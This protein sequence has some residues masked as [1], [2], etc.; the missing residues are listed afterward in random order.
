MT[1]DAHHVDLALIING[2][3]H[4]LAVYGKTLVLRSIGVVPPLKRVI[5]M[6]GVDADEDVA[7]NGLA[8]DKVG[9][10]FKAAAEASPGFLA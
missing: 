6:G 10:V 8:G 9:A 2:V 7:D 1:D 4:G 3:A 5:E